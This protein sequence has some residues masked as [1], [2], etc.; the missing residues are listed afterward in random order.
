M[1]TNLDL[2]EIF[3]EIAVAMTENRSLLCNMPCVSGET[4]HGVTMNYVFTMLEDTLAA[5]DPAGL[6][7]GEL[8]D[9]TAETFLKVDTPSARLYASG[10]RRAGSMLMR[11]RSLSDQDFGAAIAAIASGF[12]DKGTPSETL[13]DAT[14]IWTKIAPVLTAALDAVMSMAPALDQALAKI[15]HGVPIVATMRDAAPDIEGYD[16]TGLSAILMLRAIR[17]SLA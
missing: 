14:D 6:R 5:V 9:A 16:A 12:R 1:I 10:F 7:P 15:N 11:R 8:F 13:R 17:D 2:I 3:S 4:D